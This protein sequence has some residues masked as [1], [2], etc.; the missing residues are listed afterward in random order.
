[1]CTNW[2]FAPRTR[3]AQF[4]HS[5]KHFYPLFA[6]RAA[7]EDSIAQKWCKAVKTIE[8]RRVSCLAACDFHKLINTCVEIFTELKYG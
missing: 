3:S 6:P 8:E 1:V 7:A 4:L 5:A 2:R